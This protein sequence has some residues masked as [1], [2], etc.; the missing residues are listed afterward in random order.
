MRPRRNLALD[1]AS[2][3][4]RRLFGQP[5][6]IVKT[7][8]GQR[9]FAGYTLDNVIK[10]LREK[11]YGDTQEEKGHAALDNDFDST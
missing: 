4:E 1:H 10:A 11:V 7:R 9:D 3:A 6:Q 2:A 5:K 8:L